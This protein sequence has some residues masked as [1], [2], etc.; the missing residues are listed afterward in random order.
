MQGAELGHVLQQ[1]LVFSNSTEP[2]TCLRTWNIFKV[3][4][5]CTVQP[6]VV[7]W[8]CY[9]I[10]LADCKMYGKNDCWQQYWLLNMIYYYLPFQWLTADEIKYATEWCCQWQAVVRA[11]VRNSTKAANVYIQKCS[12]CI[13]QC[14][15]CNSVEIFVIEICRSTIWRRLNV[16]MFAVKC[17]D[18][19]GKVPLVPEIFC[20]LLP[21]GL[22]L[23][24]L[25]SPVQQMD[26][27]VFHVVN[28]VIHYTIGC[29][30]LLSSILFFLT[31]S[32]AP[33]QLGKSH[34]CQKSY[35]QRI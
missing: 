32:I 3:Y 10:D 34:W 13:S 12:L 26:T 2:L 29:S 22:S 11:T 35:T 7:P 21:V 27:T 1:L 23:F 8:P 9:C 19:V 24:N 14:Q 16:H 17:S 20:H 18:A 4:I 33:M 28:D 15:V 6:S 25:W 5:I 31:L 30:V